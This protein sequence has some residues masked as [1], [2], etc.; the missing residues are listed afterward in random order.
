[1]DERSESFSNLI[2]VLCLDFNVKQL[3]NDVENSFIAPT[4]LKPKFLHLPDGALTFQWLNKTFFAS[5]I[6]ICV[7]NFF[8]E[9]S[10]RL[11]FF[12]YFHRN[13]N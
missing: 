9:F 4:N 8:I 1:M 6:P 2:K 11:F 12:V 5:L 10:F 3:E 7:V 13:F